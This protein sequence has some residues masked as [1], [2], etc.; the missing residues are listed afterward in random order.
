MTFPED[1]ICIDPGRKGNY[2]PNNSNKDQFQQLRLLGLNIG[3]LL[4]QETT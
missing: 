3:L 4:T 2:R 1:L